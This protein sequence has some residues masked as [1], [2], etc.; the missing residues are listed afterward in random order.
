MFADRIMPLEI[1]LVLS[2]FLVVTSDKL[3][4][5]TLETKQNDLSQSTMF[6]EE[7][8]NALAT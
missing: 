1:P 8:Y 3:V 7:R 6:C 4:I 2:E 5:K